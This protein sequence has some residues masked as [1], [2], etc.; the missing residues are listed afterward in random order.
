[1]SGA[2]EAVGPPRRV[3]DPAARR[4][5]ILAAAASVFAERGY[6]GTTMREVARRAGVTHGLITLHFGSKEK[7]FLAAVPGTRELPGFTEG[8]TAELPHRIATS[9]VARMEQGGAPDPLI[10]LVRAAASD[11]AAA[12]RLLAAIQE[13]SV[14]PY[15]AVLDVPDVPERVALV[16]AHLMG[17][18]MSRYVLRVGPLAAMSPEDL[19]ARLTA[20]LRTILLGPVG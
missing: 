12:K 18:T 5:A 3:R 6:P 4:A 17:L 2:E 7:L 10:A 8:P 15:G 19:V 13:F 20:S 9:F 16:G 14:E 1:M 11:Q